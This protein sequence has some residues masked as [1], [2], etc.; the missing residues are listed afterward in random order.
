MALRAVDGRQHRGANVVR[1]AVLIGT[2]SPGSENQCIGLVRALGLADTLTL[3]RVTRPRGGTIDQLLRFLPVSLHK[4]IDRFLTRLLR[5]TPVF[6]QGSKRYDRVPNGGFTAGNSSLVPEVNVEKIVAVARESF[7]KEGPTMVVACGQETISSSTLIKHLASD[8][9]FVIQLDIIAK[10]P[11]FGIH[12]QHPRYRPERFDLVVTPHHDF[13]PSTA[14]GGE[15][16]APRLLR[17]WVT[18]RESPPPRNV[19]ITV[20][21]LHQADPATLSLAAKAWHDGLASLPKPLLVVNIGGPLGPGS[22]D[23]QAAVERARELVSC[24]YSA[25]HSCGSVRISFARKTPQSVANLVL[26]AFDGHPKVYIWDDKEPNPHLGHLA[27]ADAFVITPDSISMLSE[28]CST[29]KPVYVVGSDHCES[30]YSALYK[31][32]Q[33]RGAVRPFTGLEDISESWSYPPLNDAMEVATRVRE[34]IAER[35]WTVG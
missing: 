17:R 33:E 14:N 34:A 24:L 23:C 8:S 10:I 6:L 4:L 35:G 5:W 9:V 3:Y 19:V 31:T 20:G 12:I 7:E 21:A 11:V 32:L 13:Y 25:L 26:K 27:W 22:R 30:K 1:R 28:A 16:E 2:G 15:H 29:G 18:Q